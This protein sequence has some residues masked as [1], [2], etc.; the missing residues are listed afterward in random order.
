M[1]RLVHPCKAYLPSYTE[2][3]D[4]YTRFPPPQR[5]PL[6]VSPQLRSAGQV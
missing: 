6:H 5:K 1:L 2:A 3:F 4:E